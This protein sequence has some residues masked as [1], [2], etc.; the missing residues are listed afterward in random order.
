MAY[1]SGGPTLGASLGLATELAITDTQAQIESL[2]NPLR[3]DVSEVA[4]QSKA[5]TKTLTWIN[6]S[7]KSKK[8]SETATAA[9]PKGGSQGPP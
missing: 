5:L 7:L 6:S 8:D 4:S 9:A 2:I 3:A 1:T